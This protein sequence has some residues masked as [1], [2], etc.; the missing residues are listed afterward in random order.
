MVARKGQPPST[1]L[2]K[3]RVGV[4]ITIQ[5]TVQG[6]GF[7]PFIY[8]LANENQI[9]GEVANNASGVC[10]R[11][12]GTK[13]AI[14]TFISRICRELPP[15]AVIDSLATELIP[16]PGLTGFRIIESTSETEKTAI[17][18]PDISICDDCR[19]EL[20]DPRDRRYL[21]PFINCTNCG[22]RYTII[23]NLPYDRPLT[24]MKPFNFC[25]DCLT[26]YRDPE[27]RRFHA[28]ATCCPNCGPRL[29]LLDAQGQLIPCDDPVSLLATRI[30]QGD[31]VALQGLGGFHI[32]CDATNDQAVATLRERKKRPHKP[33]AVMAKDAAMAEEYGHFDESS[34][35]W[36]NSPQRP[37]VIVPERN[38]CCPGVSSE[39][40][41][42]GLFL[43]YTPLHLLLFEHLSTPIVAT[44]ANF[45][46]E[47]IITDGENLR[48]RLGRVIDCSLEFNR[49]IIN[50]SDDSVVTLAS[51]KPLFLRRARGYAPAAMTLPKQLN[52]KVLAVGGDMKNTIAIGW[53]NKAV[54]S[55][56]VGD[57]HSL[58]AENYF[59]KNIATFLRLYD[60]NP[61]M[62][63][64]DA[65]PDYFT[66]R[67]AA[68][69]TVPTITVQH[70]YAHALAAMIDCG[71]GIDDN[72]LAICWDGT[73][74]GDDGTLWGGEFLTCSFHGYQRLAHF[75][76]LPLLGGEK[77]VIEPRR[78]ALSI[79][80]QIF[81]EGALEL[82]HPLLATFSHE[83]RC[84][85]FQMW[86]RTLNTP[87]SSS[88]GRL[89][90][91]AASL[92]GICQILSYE[93]ESGL[94]METYYDA[95]IDDHYPFSC[96]DNVIDCS[97]AFC[98][99]F[100]ET[101][102]SSGVSRFINMLVEIIITVIRKADRSEALACG[103]VFQNRC[104]VERLLKR[105]AE[106]KI[107][108]HLPA[109]TPSNDGSLA[110]GQIAAALASPP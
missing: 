29:R 66:S 76:P 83:Q 15:L 13:A 72:I 109:N 84:A 110:L 28:E 67:W 34:R 22:P 35:K 49:D 78:V 43:P 14:D 41:R 70:H 32:I 100:E 10:I 94:R 93:G 51:S 25:P 50:G 105:A 38:R 4:K 108:I 81:G 104:L 82:D 77:A 55:P 37:I 62:I 87:L 8:R 20:F 53:D 5:G 106:E 27:N 39:L 101:D 65:H 11:A 26:E 102:P 59:E 56:H 18:P 89:F 71:I 74:Y 58:G 16:L 85:L 17:L 42:I 3:D 103:G 44:S 9:D 79:L 63:V 88:V 2:A 80:F 36:L 31:I 30:K 21:Y 52:R 40:D 23:R 98:A 48:R 46:E 12:A 24:A 54:L 73:G 33:F 96:E 1:P 95:D 64:C 60:F 7:R 6:V 47:P 86:Q 91:A 75:R 107:R 97:P 19:Q 92:L 68:R 69:Q 90:D 57:L 99:M 45:S 61:D